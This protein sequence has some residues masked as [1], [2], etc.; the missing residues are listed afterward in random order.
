[1]CHKLRVV[2]CTGYTTL[3][4]QTH[5]VLPDWVLNHKLGY[6]LTQVA[7]FFWGLLFPTKWATF[8]LWY[9][10]LAI[11]KWAK[12]GKQYSKE[13]EKDPIL[14]PWIQSVAGDATKAFCRHCKC[15]IRAHHAHLQRHAATT[16]H[17]Q[18]AAKLSSARTLFDV[19]CSSK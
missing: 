11:G 15:E 16:K 7:L 3:Y 5:P 1:M 13:W 17:K 6:F 2:D 18:N 4:R 14:K 9:F 19:G 10:F 8:E 12:Y